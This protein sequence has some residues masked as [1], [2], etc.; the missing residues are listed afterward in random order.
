M[1]PVKH[2]ETVRQ[3][4]VKLR[5]GEKL[6]ASCAYNNSITNATRRENAHN[7]EPIILIIICS[8]S[9]KAVY[10]VDVFCSVVSSFDWNWA[11]RFVH[12]LIAACFA[13]CRLCR[14]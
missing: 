8:R 1:L 12:I 13:A 3:F 10:A 4:A 11:C 5:A 9:R 2:T 7:V 6:R 14:R